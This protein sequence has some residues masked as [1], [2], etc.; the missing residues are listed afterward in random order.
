[1]SCRILKDYFIA[2][3]LFSHANQTGQPLATFE[4]FPC[5]RPQ[6]YKQGYFLKVEG[7]V[8]TGVNMGEMHGASKIDGKFEHLT[9]PEC[10]LLCICHK[11]RFQRHNLKG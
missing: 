7:T 10:Q 1:L 3:Q 4:I 5:D 11:D 2:L 8:K 9:L 6:S